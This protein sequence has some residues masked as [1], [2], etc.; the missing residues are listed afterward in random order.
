METK[1]SEE[2]AQAQIDLLMDFYDVDPSEAEEIFDEGKEAD[3]FKSAVNLIHSRLK[4]GIMKGFIEI[5]EEGNGLIV[6][7]NL[8]RDF[9]GHSR[10]K[11]KEIDAKAKIEMSKG[12]ESNHSEQIYR[13]LG[14]LSG[15]GYEAMKNLKGRDMKIAETI[16]SFFLQV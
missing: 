1:I 7:Q 8:M 12:K 11:Y 15:Q 4:K 5:K 9:G 2:N 3:N 16:A 6:E 13:L 10:L 14:Y